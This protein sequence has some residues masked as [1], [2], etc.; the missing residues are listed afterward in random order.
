M[1][2]HGIGLWGIILGLMVFSLTAAAD[3]LSEDKVNKWIKQAREKYQIPALAVVVIDSQQPL[4]QAIQGERRARSQDKASLEDNFHIGS[5]TKSIL[6]L[7][8]A[9]LVEQGKIRWDTP[10][11]QLLPQYKTQA[12][13]AYSEITLKQ[14]LSMRAGIQTFSSWKTIAQIGHSIPDDPSAFIQY[15][16]AQKSEVDREGDG[17]TSAYSNA[18][19]L[20]VVAMLEQASGQDWRLLVQNTMSQRYGINLGF[21]W[22]QSDDNRYVYGHVFNQQGIYGVWQQSLDIINKGQ[23]NTDSGTNVVASTKASLKTNVDAEASGVRKKDRALIPLTADGPYQ[24]PHV[25]APAGGTYMSVTDLAKYAQLHLHGARGLETP[26]SA[27]SFNQIHYAYPQLAMGV[28]NLDD[29]GTPMITF[30]GSA[31]SFYSHTMI[32]PEHDR[33]FV[34]LANS[35]T[36]LAAEGVQWLSTKIIKSTLNYWWMFWI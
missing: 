20:L 10:F 23:S 11:F 5:T 7:V 30:D 34:I 26:L 29:W 19:P 21:G 15:V 22:P 25:I 18:S 16:L 31:G 6:A 35:G 36:D 33:T 3:S 9:T 24:L 32:I 2:V 12:D 27:E 13:P 4:I 1:K 14:L 17:F 28:T 8:A